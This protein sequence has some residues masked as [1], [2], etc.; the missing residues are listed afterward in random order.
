MAVDDTSKS[1]QTQSSEPAAGSRETDARDNRPNAVPATAAATSR[2]PEGAQDLRQAIAQLERENRRLRKRCE[3][4]E[5]EINHLE[6]SLKNTENTLSFRLGY[7]LIHS[8]KSLDALRSLPSAL[9]E[10]SRDSRRRRGS[11]SHARV[12]IGVLRTSL[13]AVKL[14]SWLRTGHEP[15]APQQRR[16]SSEPD[17]SVGPG[18]D[19]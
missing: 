14:S 11:E 18:D 1:R 5:L 8:T 15:P 6:R 13:R 4:A 16:K 2:G 7:A 3:E 9:M 12:V 17:A 19:R 10:L